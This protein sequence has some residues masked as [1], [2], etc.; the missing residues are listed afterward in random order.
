LEPESA[1]KPS[2]KKG[3]ELN[4]RGTAWCI[5]V[6]AFVFALGLSAASAP[7]EAQTRG[8][9]RRDDRQGARDTR[10]DG[11][12]DARQTKQECRAGDEK[13]RPECRQDKRGTK[14]D[15]RVA[16]REVRR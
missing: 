6:A 3:P 13:S 2:S 7:V 9:E 4:S 14:Q 8:Q 1:G 10:Q 12:E 15:S 16:A 5:G 11:R